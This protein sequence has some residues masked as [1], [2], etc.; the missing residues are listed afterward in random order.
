MIVTSQSLEGGAIYGLEGFIKEDM[1]TLEDLSLHLP[2][3][4]E[5]SMKYTPV[6]SKEIVKL[7]DTECPILENVESM[8]L[9]ALMMV[10]LLGYDVYKPI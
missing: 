2:N 10:A 7:E 3:D 8:N 1:M 4:A 5:K 6:V 9:R